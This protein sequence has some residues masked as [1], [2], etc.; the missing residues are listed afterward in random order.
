MTLNINPVFE[1]LFKELNNLDKQGQYYSKMPSQSS[2]K[3]DEAKQEKYMTLD[4]LKDELLQDDEFVSS[5]V[6]KIKEKIDFN[7]QFNVSCENVAKADKSIEEDKE[8]V[9]TTKNSSINFTIPSYN[10]LKKHL[11]N[12]YTGS[13]EPNIK[14]YFYKKKFSKEKYPDAPVTYFEQHCIAIATNKSI[15]DTWKSHIQDDNFFYNLKN[16]I[17]YT[18]I[19]YKMEDD[20]SYTQVSNIDINMV[21]AINEDNIITDFCMYK[22]KSDNY[23]TTKKLLQKE[24]LSDISDICDLSNPLSVKRFYI[25][26]GSKTNFNLIMYS[27]KNNVELQKKNEMEAAVN[28]FNYEKIF[29]SPLRVLTSF[30]AMFDIYNYFKDDYT[31]FIVNANFTDEFFNS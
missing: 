21:A 25:N 12:C 3:K 8:E 14:V 19:E 27:R 11:L 15:A 2:N 30:Q 22:F 7:N 13:S 24:Y 28:I 10:K 20:F 16:D 5:L 6:D 31:M 1:E 4:E 23:E 26:F 17:M 9:E 29:N 18:Y